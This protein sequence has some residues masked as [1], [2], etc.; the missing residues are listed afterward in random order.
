[1]PSTLCPVA[2]STATWSRSAVIVVLPGVVGAEHRA[3]DV[4]VERERAVL[5]VEARRCRAAPKRQDAPGRRRPVEREAGADKQL[6]STAEAEAEA[7]GVLQARAVWACALQASALSHRI[8]RPG[9]RDVGHRVREAAGV[10]QREREGLHLH[11]RHSGQP[12]TLHVHTNQSSANCPPA[13]P[14]AA[15]ANYCGLRTLR[16]TSL[17][18]AGLLVILEV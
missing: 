9:R 11:E 17:P 16:E 8:D 6:V 10:A 1:M 2:R 14:C 3:P 18:S 5:A 15:T 12:R 7:G 4:A 13:R